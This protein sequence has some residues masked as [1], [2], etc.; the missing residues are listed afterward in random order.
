MKFTYDFLPQGAKINVQDGFFEFSSFGQTKKWPAD[1]T[2]I[3]DTGNKLMPGI[4]DHHQPDSDVKES[5]VTTLVVQDAEKYLGHLKNQSEVFLITHYVPDLDATASVY[6]AQK[7]L[8][9]EGI[10][11]TDKIIAD[12]VLEVD[13]GKLSID[14]ESPLGIASIWLAVTD[15]KSDKKPWE[16]DNAAILSKG[17]DLF[18]EVEATLKKVP[19]PWNPQ[20]GRELGGFEAEKEKVQYDL[21]AYTRD[22]K[23]R[24]KTYTI[25]LPNPLLGGLDELDLVFTSKPES[26]L[27]KYWVRGDRKNSF[28]GKGFIVTCAHWDKKSI[29]SVDPNTPYHL[30]GLGLLIDRSEMDTILGESNREDLE[31]GAPNETGDRPGK[32]DGFHR[33]D[34]WYDGRGFHNFT[35]IDA[36]R[37]GTRLM[38]SEIEQLVLATETWGLYGKLLDSKA[39]QGD[40]TWDEIMAMPLPYLDPVDPLDTLVLPDSFTFGDLSERG[41]S[42][43][44]SAL[45]N[46]RFKP[47]KAQIEKHWH[48]ASTKAY[49]DRLAA[50]LNDLPTDKFRVYK[51][52]IC[53]LVAERLDARAS[54]HFLHVTRDL[55]QDGFFRCLESASPCTSNQKQLAFMMQ[56]QNLHPEA[57]LPG[58]QTDTMF[59]D[60]VELLSLHPAADEERFELPL[61]AYNKLKNYFDDLLVNAVFA[62]KMDQE[63]IKSF[64]ATDFTSNFNEQG[65]GEVFIG[66]TILEYQHLRA[67]LIG[68]LF[69]ENLDR[70][71]DAR[72]L[73]INH[74]KGLVVK[75][76]KQYST[77]DLLKL[78]F[79]EISGLIQSLEQEKS[80]EIGPYLGVLRFLQTLAA[81]EA[82]QKRLENFTK[83]SHASF[84][85]ESKQ[86]PFLH[87]LNGLINSLFF[88]QSLYLQ[89]SSSDEAEEIL[90]GCLDQINVLRTIHDP[91]GKISLADFNEKLSEFILNI[92]SEINTPFEDANLQLEKSIAQYQTVSDDSGLMGFLEHPFPR[93]YRNLLVE[94]FAGFK[95][96]YSE[97]IHFL[98][99]EIIRLAE[100]TDSPEEEKAAIAFNRLHVDVIH[101]SVKYDWQELKDLVD[102]G[103]GNNQNFYR[104]YFYWQ[105]LNL[106]KGNQIDK[107]AELN[108]KVRF[109]VGNNHRELEAIISKLPD[110]PQAL[111]FDTLLGKMAEGGNFQQILSHFPN[112][113]L[114]QCFEYISKLYIDKFD[115]DTAQKGLFRYS[116][117]YPWYYVLLS[118]TFVLRFMTLFMISMLV[119]AGLF[120]STLYTFDET[121]EHSP[122]SVAIQSALGD[123]GFQIGNMLTSGFW[124]GLLSISFLMPF[125]VV[126]LLIYRFIKNKINQSE[127]LQLKFLELVHSTEANK[128]NLLYLSFVIP[129]LFVVLQ[130]ASTDT[131][132]MINNITGVRFISTVI[133][134]VGLTVG[135]VYMH[136]REK[137]KY[138]STAW[139][140]KRTE[141]MFWLHLFQAMLITVFIID[142]MLRLEVNIDSFGSREDLYIYGISKFIRLEVGSFD[143]II[144]PVFTILVA[145]LTLFFSFFIDKV[146]GNNN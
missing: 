6:F 15:E 124:I 146:L 77:E 111:P 63:E 72:N 96:Y 24:S 34:P 4:V 115:V 114:H 126:I 144:M 37:V 59:Q 142:L 79:G 3:L 42:Q 31:L 93:F 127:P 45:T 105:S 76:I 50:I 80:D 43:Y 92:I 25:E 116:T 69:G 122:A 128:S 46:S 117:M 134:I 145:F 51:L 84:G 97:K 21:Q 85:S 7:Y 104:K 100:L 38:E 49:L 102:N 65:S 123:A 66:E 99:E 108:S 67:K 62:Q 119:L 19:S 28:L 5:C 23:E 137:N 47:R 89:S 48:Q 8:S 64:I 83:L 26:F 39:N 14:P 54:H 121:G 106:E 135:A 2:L 88:A 71:R 132:S 74:L 112:K 32:R 33:N 20:F 40:V 109:A 57:F 118:K 1:R 16:R 138:K 120:D 113:F 101:E 29:I 143:F 86:N 133:I 61:Y 60:E 55:P 18:R 35:I 52:E 81:I 36:P 95:R 90:N 73:A 110:A 44:I 78:N 12:Y 75:T 131:I 68:V 30:K 139:V 82:L 56:M 11:D 10:T 136:V 130:M 22:I 98:R 58:A 53:N 129:L 107:L 94:I 91:E 41:Q 140:V 13:S 141:H 125:V 27:W 17:A 70:I 9:G 103:D 87:A